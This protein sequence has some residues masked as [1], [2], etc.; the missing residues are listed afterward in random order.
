MRHKLLLGLAVAASLGLTAQAQ[1]DPAGVK[2]GVLTCNVSSGWGFIFGSSKDLDCTY[3]GASNHSEDYAG[4]INKY[5]VDIGYQKGGV[6]VWAVFAPTSQLP[7]GALAGNYGGV[8]AGGSA[9]L[10]AG[11]NALVGG[12]NNTISLQPVSIEASAGLNVAAGVASISLSPA[13]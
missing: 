4:S 10:G 11:A 3:T 6:M 9:G 8:T 2:V 1:A 5:G 7:H 13:P 12:S